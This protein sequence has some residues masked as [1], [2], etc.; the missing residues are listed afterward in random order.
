MG[1]NDLKAMLDV[2]ERERGDTDPILVCVEINYSVHDNGLFMSTGIS[3]Y[4]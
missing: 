4:S 2:V 3:P 1:Q